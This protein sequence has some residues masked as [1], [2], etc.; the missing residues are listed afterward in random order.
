MT[1][2]TELAR[3]ATNGNESAIAILWTK[4]RNRLIDRASIVL[5]RYDISSTGPE[6]VASTVFA[7]CVMWTQNSQTD[8]ENRRAYWALLSR[9]TIL[10]GRKVMKREATS[11]RPHIWDAE[12]LDES[13]VPYV[14][15][16]R[17]IMAQDEYQCLLKRHPS[18]SIIL[19]MLMDRQP[20]DAI[21]RRL[22]ISVR[23]TYRIV[24]QLIKE[25]RGRLYD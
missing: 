15:D 17:N 9:A 7:E 14:D 2:I 19:P 6:E 3:R 18:A 11:K 25:L 12:S 8:I 4:Y 24:S 5:K 13:K 23:S 22:G 1:S 16:E 20:M 21:A 10:H